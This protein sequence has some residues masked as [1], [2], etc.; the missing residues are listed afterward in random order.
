MRGG[1][2][3]EHPGLVGGDRV[4]L[5]GGECGRVD[6]ALGAPQ[7]VQRQVVEVQPQQHALGGALAGGAGEPAPGA[8]PAADAVRH[9]DGGDVHAVEFGGQRGAGERGDPVQGGLAADPDGHRAVRPQGAADQRGQ[10]G[11]GGEVGAGDVQDGGGGELQQGAGAF[12]GGGGGRAAGG[13]VQHREPPRSCSGKA[14]LSQSEGGRPVRRSLSPRSRRPARRASAAPT[15]RSGGPV[16]PATRC[17][18][19]CT[20]GTRRCRAR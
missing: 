12:G 15:G 17:C 6:A 3:L 14:N 5:G 1:Q 2:V 7:V 13:P 4:G 10:A 9:G 19:R 18:A 11:A 20:S 16:P 8:E